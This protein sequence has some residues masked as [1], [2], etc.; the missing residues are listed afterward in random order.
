MDDPAVT[1]RST[2]AE[3]FVRAVAAGDRDAVRAM[4]EPAVDFRGITP[5]RSWLHESAEDVIATMCG[6]W[7]GGERRIDEIASLVT[8]DAGDVVRVGYRFHATTP[9][10]PA[11]VEQ[12]AYLDVTGDTIRAVR[13]VCSGYQPRPAAAGGGDSASRSTASRSGTTR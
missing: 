5:N 11:F 1:H 3:G 4:L 8:D 10:G 13:L 2:V 6:Q 12:Q 7:F 9:S